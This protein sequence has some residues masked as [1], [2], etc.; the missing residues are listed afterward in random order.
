[1]TAFVCRLTEL[2]R[3]FSPAGFLLRRSLREESVNPRINPPTAHASPFNTS[4][5]HDPARA[6]QKRHCA[7]ERL[8]IIAKRAVCASDVPFGNN[9]QPMGENVV[10]HP[11]GMLYV[12]VAPVKLSVK[13]HSIW[14]Q[15]IEH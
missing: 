12:L 6:V 15:I 10:G 11:A 14:E 3:C 1:M 4:E 2:L 7:L 13:A 5:R 9:G 8:I